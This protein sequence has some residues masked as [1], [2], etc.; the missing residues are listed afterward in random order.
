MKSFDRLLQSL[1]WRLFPA[2]GLRCF[3]K[4][5]LQLSVLDK[6]DWAA[7]SEIF[8]EQSYAPFFEHFGGVRRWVDLGSNAGFF[9]LALLDHLREKVGTNVQTAAFLL[10]ASKKSLRKADRYLEENRLQAIWRTIPCVIG[11]EGKEVNFYEYKYSVASSVFRR[12]R[13]ERVSR[14]RTIPLAR[15]LGAPAADFDLL[16]VDIEGAELFLLQ[17]EADFV[18]HFPLVVLEWHYDFP[19]PHLRQWIA[20][21]S[22]E[23]IAL[24]STPSDWDPVRQGHSWE[25]PLGVA[26]WRNRLNSH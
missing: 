25:S 11:P 10:D 24:R 3:S 22:G 8:I 19:G 9:S 17:Q 1:A 23:V 12:A 13:P 26:L 5:G 7:C 18:A 14:L 15:A 20:D 2:A 21:H 6:G 4:S 16:K